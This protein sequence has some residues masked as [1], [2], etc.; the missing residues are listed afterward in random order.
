MINKK[1]KNDN[2]ILEPNNFYNTQ[3]HPLELVMRN[4]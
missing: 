3:M 4:S 2:V 1:K